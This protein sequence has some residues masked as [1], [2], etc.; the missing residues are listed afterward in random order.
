MIS[1]RV[2]LRAKMSLSFW[3]K[4]KK[5]YLEVRGSCVFLMVPCLSLLRT[6]LHP[7]DFCALL[8]LG[9]GARLFTS[10]AHSHLCLP[11]ALAHLVYSTPHLKLNLF[12]WQEHILL[13]WDQC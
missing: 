2:V 10:M 3:Q 4:K 9:P 13:K 8:E 7:P 5:I 11:S 6:F 1:G 12:P